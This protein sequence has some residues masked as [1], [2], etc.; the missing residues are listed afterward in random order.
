[1]DDIPVLG[2]LSSLEDEMG[3]DLFGANSQFTSENVVLKAPEAIKLEED[4]FHVFKD[5]Y[6]SDS[7]AKEPPLRALHAPLG[8]DSKGAVKVELHGAEPDDQKVL[9][10][11]PGLPELSPVED[12][13]LPRAPPAAYNVHFLSSLLAQHRSSSIVPLG[14]WPREGAPHSGLR[15]IP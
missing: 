2:A 1:M 12:T 15:V 10:E 11:H 14:A 7:E 9:V 8:A 3:P 13:L 5:P 4:E 6:L